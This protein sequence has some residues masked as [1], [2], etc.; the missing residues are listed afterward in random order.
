MDGLELQ[1]DDFELKKSPEAENGMEIFGEI[2]AY[3]SAGLESWLRA[4]DDQA[5]LGVEG[6]RKIG[7]FDQGFSGYLHIYPKDISAVQNQL[8]EAGKI[9]EGESLKEKR[10][11]EDSGDAILPSF[12]HLISGNS[13]ADLE[14]AGIS[15]CMGDALHYDLERVCELD[16]PCSDVLLGWRKED[17]N[18]H[19]RDYGTN[20]LVALLNALSAQNTLTEFYQSTMD[21][22][23]DGTLSEDDRIKGDDLQR[24]AEQAR[25]RWWHE[26]RSAVERKRDQAQMRE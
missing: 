5:R 1:P 3:L 16:I 26:F 21:N 14:R 12:E 2:P 23:L 8:R 7:N 19:R 6:L 17:Y 13:D 11:I 15:F 25:E 22:D 20:E 9:S 24:I 4:C 18:I 10:A